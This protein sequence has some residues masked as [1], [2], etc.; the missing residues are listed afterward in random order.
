MK[1]EIPE[2]EDFEQIN[3]IAIQVHEMHV[4]WQPFRFKSSN[5][6]IDN[7]RLKKLIDDKNIYV[8]KENNYIVGY[9]ILFIYEKNDNPLMHYRKV[10]YIDS[11]AIDEK[12]RGKDYGTKFINFIK[13]LG[14]NLDCTDIELSVNCENTSA[15]KLYEKMGMKVKDVNYYIKI[16]R[17]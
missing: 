15:I 16:K 8:I 4:K 7:N 1:I 2:L 17:N 14:E 9:T 3:K 12:F 6:V 10:L 13:K 11:L 5:I